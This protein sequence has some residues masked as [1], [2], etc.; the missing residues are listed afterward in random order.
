M[1]KIVISLAIV[2]PDGKE[3]IV[4]VLDYIEIGSRQ[5]ETQPQN[6]EQLL[7]FEAPLSK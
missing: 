1:T 5:I 2:H 6:Q 3:E 4:E 7:L